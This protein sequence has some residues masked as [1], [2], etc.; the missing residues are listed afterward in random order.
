MVKKLLAI[1]M[2]MTL[3]LSV[4]VVAFAADDDVPVPKKITLRPGDRTLDKGR[5][6]PTTYTI[7]PS[8]AQDDAV[9]T[10]SSGDEDIC[11]VD[12][13]GVI[14]AVGA[15]RVKITARTQNGVTGSIT[16]T[17]PGTTSDSSRY[18]NESTWDNSSSS[19]RSEVSSVSSSRISS[20]AA[21]TTKTET[22][23]EKISRET[24]IEAV[25]DAG[26]KTVKLKN[27][28]SVSA[29]SLQAAAAESK[30]LLQFDTMNG[31]SVTGR[32]TINSSLASKLTGDI[33]LGVY[34]TA[35]KTKTVQAAIDDAYKNDTKVIYCEQADYGMNVTIT[36][37][38]GTSLDDSNL[39]VYSCD[40]NGKNVEEVK[41]TNLKIDSKGFVKFTTS[42]GGYLIVSDGALK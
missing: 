4:G 29:A 35:A 18:E 30:S 37:K 34:A 17:V 8:D 40:K 9:V 33:K 42:T 41:V 19:S 39:K 23:R 2:V 1:L 13:D 38:V 26:S 20:S 31:K 27:Y 10:Y 6:L 11:E 15:G 25:Q 16:I 36:A 3:V 21:S 24:L 22:K 5:E 32:L 7:S 28:S 12:A 14:K